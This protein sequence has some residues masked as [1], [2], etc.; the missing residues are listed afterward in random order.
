MIFNTVWFLACFVVF[1]SMFLL[2]PNAKVR[3]YFTLVSSAVF[4]FHFAGPAGI[5]P[6]VI[7]GVITFFFGIALDLLP[8]GSRYRKTVFFVAVVA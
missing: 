2:I 4:H 1:F 5:I 7:M 8:K 6:V 3:F